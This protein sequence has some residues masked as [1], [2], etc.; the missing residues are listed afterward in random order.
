MTAAEEVAAL[1]PRVAHVTHA[2]LAAWQ[3]SPGPLKAN[4]IVIYDWEALTA[5]DTGA[6]LTAARRAGLV[7]GIRGLW[8]A[9]PKA[10]E[11]KSALEDRSLADEEAR[12]G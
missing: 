11:L 9:S 5:R 10:H 8:F 2:L 6:A 1:S 12:D 3:E 4:E 7:D